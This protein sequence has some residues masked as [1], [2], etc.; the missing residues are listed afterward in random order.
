MGARGVLG[1]EEDII[2]RGTTGA[3]SSGHLTPSPSQGEEDFRGGDQP[4]AQRL[5]R[6]GHPHRVPLRPAKA[7]K[8]WTPKMRLPKEN[9][10]DARGLEMEL[11]VLMPSRRLVP[12]G[13]PSRKVAG[14][15][16]PAVRRTPAQH[17][18]E[19]RHNI[20]LI[21]G[22]GTFKDVLDE[23]EAQQTLRS[24]T[25]AGSY[26]PG[27]M[28]ARAALQRKKQVRDAVDMWWY[29]ALQDAGRHPDDGLM[30]KD[31]VEI[32]RRIQKLLMPQTNDLESE[33]LA[34][35]EWQ[36]AS[37][38]QETIGHKLFSSSMFDLADLWCPDC[39]EH[40]YVAFLE[41]ALEGT[42]EC[43][44]WP[45][46]RW[47]PLTHIAP[48]QRNDGF[49][50]AEFEA[51]CAANGDL[52]SQ[53]WNLFD[54]SEGFHKLVRK[55]ASVVSQSVVGAVDT[56]VATASELSTVAWP[57]SEHSQKRA[58]GPF[59][60]E[61]DAVFDENAW[62]N[63]MKQDI[64]SRRLKRVLTSPDG[65]SEH[66]NDLSE[67]SRIEL[68]NYIDR[69][70]DRNIRDLG[71]SIKASSDSP[72]TS[73]LKW[74]VAHQAQVAYLCIQALLHSKSEDSTQLLAHL[75]A[76]LSDDGSSSLLAGQRLAGSADDLPSYDS[77]RL[78]SSDS[79]GALSTH[80][81]SSWGTPFRDFLGPGDALTKAPEQHRVSAQGG[82]QSPPY[83]E[84][85]QDAMPTSLYKLFWVELM[86]RRE[87]KWAHFS[88][89]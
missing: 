50:Q 9:S 16:P 66:E 14:R 72:E 52:T 17:A 51:L 39:S 71:T 15:A 67:A 10:L 19:E 86:E 20:S 89:T 3:G 49:L 47:L 2:V 41:Y 32:H 74:Q 59:D 58:S 55:I 24:K 21:L 64:L 87:R 65:V 28:R 38:G 18:K 37:Q 53:T 61:L 70:G 35:V 1:I 4:N 75:K 48:I 80:R 77:S 46:V 22:H 44:P 34:L 79:E 85:E 43:P 29:T 83:A 68:R 8:A 57:T 45:P 69:A 23:E 33:E 13:A 84:L 76:I 25:K 62:R 63:K 26:S 30:R 81:E 88:R 40:S 42:A 31:F 12:G 36:H 7:G 11:D 54:S 6:S 78:G 60:G 27:A 56:P 82:V 5:S 73:R